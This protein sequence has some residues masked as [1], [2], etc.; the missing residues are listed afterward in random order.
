MEL[1]LG[2]AYLER[3]VLENILDVLNRAFQ[4]SETRRLLV[5]QLILKLSGKLDIA[6]RDNRMSV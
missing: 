4:I 6:C 5:L 1:S 3:V 2:C